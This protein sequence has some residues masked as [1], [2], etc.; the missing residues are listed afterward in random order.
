MVAVSLKK[1]RSYDSIGRYGGEEFLVVLP[2]SDE[3]QA[4]QLA[5]RIRIAVASELFRFN[6]V[7]LTIT[8][9]QGVV[10]WN[11][12]FSIPIER[13]IQTVDQALYRVKHN[14][15]DGIE[16]VQFDYHPDEELTPMFV[17]PIASD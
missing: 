12:P 10:T 13:L 15:R 4:V 2:N 6:H 11:E 1:K 9:S 8:L 3:V 17:S 16:H 5:E 7:D 14:G